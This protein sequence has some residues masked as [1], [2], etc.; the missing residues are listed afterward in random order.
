MP[1]PTERLR[2]Q[3]MTEADLPGVATLDIAASRGPAGWIAWTRRNDVEHGFGSWVVETHAGE[4]VGDCGLTCKKWRVRGPSRP[5]GT[6][7]L[8]SAVRDV[9]RRPPGPCGTLRVAR[10]SGT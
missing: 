7:V 9:R 8:T 4:L 10:V 3:E 6:Y 2:F 5:V 1:A